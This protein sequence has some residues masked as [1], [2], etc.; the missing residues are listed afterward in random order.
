VE[1]PQ[2]EAVIDEFALG[3]QALERLGFEAKEEALLASM[4]IYIFD[5]GVMK[6]ELLGSEATDFGKEVIPAALERHRVYAY[7]YDGYWRD[8][9]TI[10]A[11][12]HANIELAQPIPPLN[13]YDTRRPVYT[14]P[15]FLPGTKING[16][17]I[18]HSILCE[19]S[20]LY[21][22][23]INRSIIGLRAI[24]KRGSTL[25]RTVLMGASVF[26][27]VHH[28]DD[29]RIPIGVGQGCEIR[30]AIIDTNARIGEGSRLVNERGVQEE[31]GDFY[32]IRGGVIVIP[33][34]AEV[35][36]GTVL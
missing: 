9:G 32:H 26:E 36:P 27:L 15:R 4:G 2:D 20:I 3:P 28:R 17:E 35:P 7:G 24:V 23:E 31:D 30:N 13:L 1:K 33:W 10:P 21:G 16:C 6:E 12:H 11:F 8:I 18:H 5:S 25:D 34:G 29:S 22:S 14:H 19:G